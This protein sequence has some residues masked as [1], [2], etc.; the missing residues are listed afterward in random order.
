M[1]L[2]IRTLALALIAVGVGLAQDQAKSLP[3]LTDNAALQYWF[4]FCTM[5]ETPQEDLVAGKAPAGHALK[6][7]VREVCERNRI[8]V[9]DYLRKGA[10]MSRCD[11]GLD[12]GR[13]LILQLPHLAK[14]RTLARCAVAYG[15]L[16]EAEGKH[17]DAA[18]TY[19]DV[20][21]MGPQI[22]QD[23]LLVSA[24]VGVAVEK[25]GSRAIRQM[26]A[27]EPPADVCAYVLERLSAL[28]DPYIEMAPR[29]AFEPILAKPAFLAAFG[30]QP[31]PSL[32]E[33]DKEDIRKS[34]LGFEGDGLS[35]AEREKQIT[36]ILRS[37]A[38]Y[39]EY[40]A[41]AQMAAEIMSEPYP[42]AS[43]TLIEVEKEVRES[44]NPI[45]KMMLPAALGVMTHQVRAQTEMRATRMLAAA[46]L[47]KAKAGKYPEKLEDLKPYFPTG[48]PR[49][50]MADKDFSYR[51]DDGRPCLQSA[52]PPPGVTDNNKDPDAYTFSFT[53]I[54]QIE[55]GGKT[56]GAK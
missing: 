40:A 2:A 43:V 23:R 21:A 55:S 26:L 37:P 36:A 41:K 22:A 47:H 10:K 20:V 4:A 38:S 6:P 56:W 11:F 33:R 18:E 52:G 49:D 1:K 19:C 46:A 45:V 51:L 42:T 48:I 5:D 32:T 27:H 15:K 30:N 53:R 29:V 34:I 25:V 14:A 35:A 3:P 12:Y 24:L 16:L 9:E 7:K 13:G 44:P 8:A 39:D 50:P 28:P 31:N 17:R 54:L